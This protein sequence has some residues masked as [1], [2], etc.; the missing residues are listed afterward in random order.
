MNIHQLR[1]RGCICEANSTNDPAC[2]LHGE[3]SR[4]H[5]PPKP[6]IV[7]VL[8]EER[9]DRGPEGAA[10]LSVIGV[11]E[12][13]GAA[14]VEWQRRAEFARAGGQVVEGDEHAGDA[15]PDDWDVTYRTEPFP[16]QS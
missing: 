2:P 11:Y 9:N 16:V 8:T 3:R 10:D 4:T 6:A 7:W 14:R 12:N 5:P 13:E 1:A 15:D